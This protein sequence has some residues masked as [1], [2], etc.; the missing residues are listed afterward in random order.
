[1]QVSLLRCLWNSGSIIDTTKG[2]KVVC[3]NFKWIREPSVVSKVQVTQC[4][5]LHVLEVKCMPGYLAA[6]SPLE[7]TL[8]SLQ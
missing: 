8:R 4:G 3:C 1:M 2:G 5:I 6:F 7:T